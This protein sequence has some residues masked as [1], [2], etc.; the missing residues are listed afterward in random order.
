LKQLHKRNC[1]I[2]AILK[3]SGVGSVPVYEGE[4]RQYSELGLYGYKVG[5]SGVDRKK[6][7]EI[8][9]YIIEKK[10]LS[11]NKIISLLNGNISLR[12]GRSDR[13]F[14]KAIHD[15]EEDIEYVSNYM[16]RKNS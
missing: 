10:I 1:F 14:T 8:L 15:W 9:D 16:Q 13:D 5:A 2:D 12:K 4:F 7:H 6:R 3:Y 11:R